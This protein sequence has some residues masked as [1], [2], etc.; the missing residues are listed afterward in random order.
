MLVFMLFVMIVLLLGKWKVVC[1]GDLIDVMF[2]DFYLMQGVIGYDQI[3]YKFGCY[4]LQFDKKFDDFCVDEGF[5]GVV[6][7]GYMV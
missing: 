6:L 3:Y 1:V 2:G 5:G 4:E 7:S